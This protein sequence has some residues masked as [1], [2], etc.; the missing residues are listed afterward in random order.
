[1][2]PAAAPP[3]AAK[4]PNLGIYAKSLHAPPGAGGRF[5]SE[6]AAGAG[7]EYRAAQAADPDA[8]LKSKEKRYTLQRAAAGLLFDRDLH[9]FEQPYRVCTCQRS[10][11][12]E[13]VEILAAADGDNA[14]FVGLVTCGSVWH[15]PVCAAK[16]AELRRVEIQAGMLTW[17]AAGGDVALMT[18]TNPH[19]A[20]LDLA[21][22]LK[23]QA[24]ARQRFK[25]CRTYKR[26]MRKYGRAGS[27]CSLEVTHGENGFH[28]HCHELIF[29]MPAADGMTLSQ[30]QAAIDELRSEWVRIL[31][32]VD[33][34]N[35]EKITDMQAHALDL[36]GGGKAAD[37]IAKFGR[38]PA[39]SEA[40]EL[41][42]AHAKV[43]KRGKFGGSHVTPFQL[44]QNFCDGDAH[45]GVLFVEYAKAFNGKR[46]LSFSQGLKNALGLNDETDAALADAADPMPVEKFVYSLNSEQW[47][48]VLSRNARGE[49]LY[50]A[51]K[52]GAA[53]VTC[54]LYDLE[55]RRPATHSGGSDLYVNRPRYRPPGVGW[56]ANGP[57][58]SA[59]A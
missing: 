56:N 23:K 36:R 48:L 39:W 51:A 18:L 3:A 8:A 58:R 13:T 14:R 22:H 1:M 27:V 41:T 2:T 31:F 52:N 47:R 17:A 42:K 15:C 26:V 59:H 57:A 20:D 43:G 9:P 46:M 37:Y 35:A 33:L 11:K 6:T 12:Q 34:G 54:L 21:D 49:L 29:T 4:R 38:D 16:V 44:L 45:A 24:Q 10:R 55:N 53:G 32:R 19:T 7:R 40:H 28:P 25:N 5:Y 50:I 30:D